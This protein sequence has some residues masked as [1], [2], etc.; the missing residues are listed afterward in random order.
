MRLCLNFLSL[1]ALMIAP[2]A[3]PA[4]AMAAE[5]TAVECTDLALE[6]SGHEMPAGEDHD[7]GQACCI[8]VPPAIDPSLAAF[9]PPAMINHLAF[10]APIQPFQLGAGPK[11]ENPPPRIA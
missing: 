2:L 1:T 4:A 3:V 7:H 5:P 10:V 8:A 6:A 9:E 11:A